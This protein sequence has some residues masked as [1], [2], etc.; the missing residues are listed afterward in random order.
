MK[1]SLLCAHNAAVIAAAINN[2]FDA[3]VIG[4]TPVVY[5]IGVFLC[6]SDIAR[7]GLNGH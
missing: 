7:R 6:L 1:L 5:I 3:H 2:G 4:C